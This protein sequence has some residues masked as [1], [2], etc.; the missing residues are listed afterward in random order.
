MLIGIDASRA[1]SATPTG[2]EIYSRELIR[3][4]VA[5]DRTN[6]YRLYTRESVTRDFFGAT[7][8]FEIRAMPFPRL[9]TH[10]RLSFEMLTRAPDV[11]WIP[12]H[13]LPPVHPRRSIVTI[14]DLGHLHF[15]N[16]HPRLQ[17]AY[18]TWATR[19]N[20]R[21]AAHVFADSEATRDDIVR[22]CNVPVEKITVIYPAFDAQRFQPVRD[23]TQLED[24]RT[25]LRIA[26]DYLLAIG[27]IHPRKNYARL[28][29]AFSKLQMADGK[30]RIADSELVIV[31][32]RGWLHKPI[33]ELVERLGLQS[34]VRF[35]D[36]VPASD[37][38][39]LVSGARVLA[40]PSLHEG[41]GLPVLEAHACGTPV[42]CSMTS[43]LPEAAGDAALF[44]DP[45]DVD[46]IA[47]ALQRLDD[48]NALRGK[49][50]AKGFEN[51]QRFSWEASA[52]RVLG[53]I[54][55]T[56]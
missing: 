47:G 50:I 51:L 17:R 22:F 46:A 3:A 23:A 37:M 21:A 35:L 41:F 39:A 7:R 44:V 31:G 55:G 36:Y 13:V 29:E 49:L 6:A 26:G 54:R 16:A 34:R 14:H 28:I 52:S 1:T 24:T 40:F 5:M 25:R 48:D 56:A 27:T 18:H 10:A 2:T 15:P 45:F 38:P 33:F 42:V 11:L 12:A 43:S 19:Y 32:K 9:W 30:S 53:V 8:N 20:A 4:L